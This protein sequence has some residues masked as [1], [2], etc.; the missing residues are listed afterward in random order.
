MIVAI[1]AQALAPE[2]PALNLTLACE[3]QYKATEVT[4]ETVAA[5][6]AG[7]HRTATGTSVTGVTRTGTGYASFSGATGQLTYPD[8]IRRELSNV[9]ATDQQITASY[10]RKWMLVTYTW[11]LDIDRLTGAIRVVNGSD[12]TFA[13]TCA[14]VSNTPKF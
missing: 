7:G 2:A 10:Q 14:P 13:G 11:K 9:V 3:G 12:V 4:R 8:G 5:D 6:I 1:L